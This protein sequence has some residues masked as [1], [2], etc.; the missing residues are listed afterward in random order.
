MPYLSYEEYKKLGFTELE[1][2]EFNKLTKKASDVLDSVTRY[3]YQAYDID[4]DIPF[5]VNQFKKAVAAQIEFF[6]EIGAT[7]TY[8]M[9]DPNSI[10]IGRTTM[11]KGARNS[12]NQDDKK[13]SIVSDDVYMYLKDTG[14]LYTG[15][16]VRS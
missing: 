11:S 16:G 6:H 15:L 1:E 7:T 9:N 3:F 5:R 10:T 13:Q 4:D 8:G 2:T 12:S 14:L